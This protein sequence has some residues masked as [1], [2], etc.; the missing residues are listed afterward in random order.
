M[1]AL[2]QVLDSPEPGGGRPRIKVDLYSKPYGL[3]RNAEPKGT[4]RGLEGV[5]AGESDR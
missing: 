3:V 5:V 4:S 2:S 1:P